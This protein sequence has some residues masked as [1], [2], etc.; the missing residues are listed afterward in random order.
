MFLS[1]TDLYSKF[2]DDGIPTHN[3][4]GELL[5]KAALKKLQKEY[6]KQMELYEKHAG[7]SASSSESS[8]SG[9]GSSVV[10]S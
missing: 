10:G 1:L 2:A 7:K 9:S 5:P 8:S 3:K 4:A 6:T